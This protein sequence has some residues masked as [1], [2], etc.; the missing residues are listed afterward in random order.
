MKNKQLKTKKQSMATRKKG[1]EVTSKNKK[2][3]ED[4]DWEKRYKTLLDAANDGIIL[5]NKKSEIA[6][7]IIFSPPTNNVN[8]SINVRRTIK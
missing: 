2:K 8:P 5:I 4:S 1:M 3:Y 6:V 7:F